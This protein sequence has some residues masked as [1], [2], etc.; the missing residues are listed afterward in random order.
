MQRR[1][2]LSIVPL[3]YQAAGLD[4]SE[5]PP[6]S[7]CRFKDLIHDFPGF[8]VPLGTYGPGVGVFHPLF[9]PPGLAEHG[10]YPL[11]QIEGFKSGDDSRDTPRSFEKAVRLHSDDHRNMTGEEEPVELSIRTAQ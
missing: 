1:I 7:I 9:P 3:Q 4:F 5:S 6:E 10:Q 8:R 2:R 11:Q